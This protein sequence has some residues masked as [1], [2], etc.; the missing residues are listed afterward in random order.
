MCRVPVVRARRVRPAFVALGLAFAVAGCGR[1]DH[2]RSGPLTFEELPDST[3]LTRGAP[4]L[5]ALEPY[6]MT[7]GAMRVR[8]GVRLPDG[9]RVQVTVSDARTHTTV[10][11]LQVSIQDGRFETPPFMSERGPL[12]PGTYTFDLLAYFNPAWQS[13]AV[14]RATHGGGALRGPGIVRTRDGGVVFHLAEDRT[15]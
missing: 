5:G 7:G 8:G 3:G 15:L 10:K 6:R 13:D 14:L 1:N 11:A 9:T 2:P 12:P 4:I